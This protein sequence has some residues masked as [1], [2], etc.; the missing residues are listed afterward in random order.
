MPVPSSQFLRGINVLQVGESRAVRIA[1]M[2]LRDHGAHVV[3]TGGR[4]IDSAAVTERS[5]DFIC[6][7]PI[8]QKKVEELLARSDI[9]ID[10]EEE[11]IY[12]EVMNRS[13][14]SSKHIIHC[15]LPS[16][17]ST[18][19]MP[20]SWDEKSVSAAAGLY[21]TPSG[22]GRPRAF[23][24]P[25]A[26]TAAAF[27]AV[28]SIAMALVGRERDGSGRTLRIPLERVALS[29]QVL[30][31]MIRSRPPVKWEPFRWLASPFM[32]VWK[33]AG[34]EHI[35][36]H[37]G[38]PRHLRTFLFLIESEGFREEKRMIRGLLHK[39][40]RRDPSRVAG[41]GEALRIS[42]ALANLFKKRSAGYWEK[43]LGEA[44]L[45]CAKVRTFEEWM[46]HPQVLESGEIISDTDLRIPGMVMNDIASDGWVSLEKGKKLT[47]DELI[48]RWEKR[49]RS[50]RNESVRLPLEGVRVLDLSRII[51]GPFAGRQ[52]AEFG[53]DVMYLSLRSNQ[54]SWEEPFHVAFN[55][56][57]RAAAVDCSRPGGREK[58][59]EIIARFNPDIVIHNFLDTPAA[60]LGIDYESLK[61]INP[62]I[63]CVGIKAYNS[64]GPWSGRS[65]FEQNIQAASGMMSDYS[66]KKTPEIVPVAF[67]DLSTGLIGS[68]GAA[69]C[70]LQL[71]KGNG[72]NC[73]STSLTVPAMYLQIE[74]L[75]GAAVERKHLS[76]FYRAKDGWFYLSVR[77]GKESALCEMLDLENMYTKKLLADLFKS[78]KI[79]FWVKRI[80][81]L[82]LQGLLGIVPRRPLMNL[83]GEETSREDGVF[84]RRD[85]DYGRILAARSPVF[86]KPQRIRELAPAEP[87]NT[88]SLKK[89][90]G[91]PA[92][93]FGKIALK[94]KSNYYF[95]L[96]NQCR[97]AV[98]ILY[99]KKLCASKDTS[100]PG[101]VKK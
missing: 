65:G 7:E 49:K 8:C 29:V 92:G 18:S 82:E 98:V 12:R 77:E 1:A 99:Q 81:Q 15:S 69:L 20:A 46:N 36:L 93:I 95:W 88:G 16:F 91:D 9:V 41:I 84:F 59:R 13:P 100:E 28:N 39:D 55:A 96:A 75:N 72:G 60:K 62:R 101:S 22:L 61:M 14:E 90:S 74:K 19:E 30:V 42:H 10:D 45:C 79:S 50:E 57:K 89:V 63:I 23:E 24:L 85:H 26:S 86:M 97:W 32:G 40:T 80:E 4:A 56:G 35:Y 47:P 44:G 64:R 43:L 37:I 21:E 83:I 87:V 34:D 3:R 76:D 52:L 2:I 17:S 11:S 71:M 33:A 67:N 25:I 53:A 6:N 73:I 58:L 70:F 38:M 78:Q 27:Y 48:F 31:A 54:L 94:F 66:G 68:F 51:A 5:K